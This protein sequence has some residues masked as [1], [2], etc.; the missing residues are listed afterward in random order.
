MAVSPEFPW[1][2]WFAQPIV[3][4]I[5]ATAL[6]SVGHTADSSEPILRA[7]PAMSHDVEILDVYD[8]CFGYDVENCPDQQTEK[9]MSLSI[10]A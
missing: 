3:S 9:E 2:I 1:R 10:S 4:P 5:V 6:T 8:P 7:L